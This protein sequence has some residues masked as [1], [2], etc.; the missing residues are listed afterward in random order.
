MDRRLSTQYGYG[1]ARILLPA[2][3][4]YRVPR[5]PRW[6]LHPSFVGLVGALVILSLLRSCVTP[7]TMPGR[8][9][10]WVQ[11]TPETAVPEAEAP[12][13]SMPKAARAPAVPE[14]KPERV[15]LEKPRPI[16][17]VSPPPEPVLLKKEHKTPDRTMY[18]AQ[19][20]PAPAPVSAPRPGL[21]KRKQTP[22]RRNAY[23]AQAQP[24]ISPPEADYTI[25][26]KPVAQRT[27][28]SRP[29]Q[30]V[31]SP[32]AFIP[33][34]AEESIPSFSRSAAEDRATP[35]TLMSGPAIPGDNAAGSGV[36]PQFQR[37]AGSGERGGVASSVS[38]PTGFAVTVPG[39]LNGPM[40]PSAGGETAD[41]VTI[42][43][44]IEGE[45]TRIA[46]L[47][48]DIYRKAQSTEFKAGS[49]C[50]TIDGVACRIVI[51]KEKRVRLSFSRESISFDV[52]SKLER[53]LPE[54]VKPCAD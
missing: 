33:L 37:A 54:G 3:V 21:A 42:V 15:L 13:V 32:S 17:E 27:D 12:A 20:R 35:V 36:A 10:L 28:P 48:Q 19:D 14:K 18:D 6:Y 50:T 16:E 24:D 23:T 30:E 52:V 31:A 40:A 44:T 1:A 7:V 47:K 11:Q 26:E 22:E 25:R 34:P 4:S 2:P 49:Y 5:H 41:M 39:A 29:R 53:R 43:G 46:T 8:T 9:I 45:S 51:T 38:R